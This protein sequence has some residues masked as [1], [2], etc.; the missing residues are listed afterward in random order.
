MKKPT[1][2]DRG[3][4]V[5]TAALAKLNQLAPLLQEVNRRAEKEHANKIGDMSSNLIVG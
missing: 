3:G 5:E 4:S 1:K 2:A